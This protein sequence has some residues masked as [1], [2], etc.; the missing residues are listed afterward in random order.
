MKEDRQINEMSSVFV[1]L[2]AAVVGML[3]IALILWKSTRGDN[4][5]YYP[6]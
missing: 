6:W 5:D 1:F 4:D 2:V 3:V